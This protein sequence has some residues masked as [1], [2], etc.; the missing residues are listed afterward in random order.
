MS[1]ERNESAF[2]PR[3]SSVLGGLPKFI[4]SRL[5]VIAD[6]V[7]MIVGGWSGQAPR[8]FMTREPLARHKLATP[9]RDVLVTRKLR[10]ARVIRETPDAVSLL[11]AD[12]TGKRISFVPGQFFT[13]LV[14]LPD[15]EVVK[16]AYSISNTPDADGAVSEARIT[17]KRIP[18][19]VV[20]N[21]LNDHAAEGMA[22]EVLGPSGSFTTNVV[23]TN[24][25]HIALFAGGSGITPLMSIASTV[26]AGEPSSRV[27]LVYGNRSAA[28]VIFHDELAALVTAHGDRFVV[29][30]VLTNPPEGFSGRSGLLD[31]AAAT[32]ELDTLPSADEYFVC[33]PEPM[34]LAVREALEAR[35]VAA[36]SIREERYSSPGRRVRQSTPLV[37]QRML[38]RQGSSAREVMAKAG[39]TVLEAGLEAALPMPFSCSMGG[40][41]AC[42]VKLVEGEVVSDEPNCL[43]ADEKR[44]GFVLACVSRPASACVVEVP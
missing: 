11:L 13:L 21:Y 29:R 3:A 22:V 33:G 7:R 23:S 15:G 34:M 4:T 42:R 35:G 41:G 20:S 10:I 24:R 25:R 1:T 19:G 26:L 27:S 30:H 37:P 40:C 8:S 31:R 18:E 12:P 32:A 44:A 17:I 6:D 5:E 14:H 16:R 2:S 28:D 43:S 9:A 39:Q 38:V 36:S